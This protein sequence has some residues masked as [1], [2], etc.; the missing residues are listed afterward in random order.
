MALRSAAEGFNASAKFLSIINSAMSFSRLV[1]KQQ[2][3]IVCLK[4]TP[5]GGATLLL[6][7]IK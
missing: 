4:A 1:R 6:A 2:D 3:P 5:N 7:S